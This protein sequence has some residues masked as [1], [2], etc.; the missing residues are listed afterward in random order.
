MCFK[1]DSLESSA[2]GQDTAEHVAFMAR[3]RL[4]PQPITT[5]ECPICDRKF[6]GFCRDADIIRGAG[7]DWWA[8]A[9]A[10][11]RAE[12]NLPAEHDHVW[13]TDGAH[14]NEFCGVCFVSKPA[15]G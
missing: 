5:I 8:R 10:Q 4:R 1:C 14:Q 15:E 9:R 13:R 12:N 2:A 7:R 6:I 3:F 11:Y